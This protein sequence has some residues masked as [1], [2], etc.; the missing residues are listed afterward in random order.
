MATL[1]TTS[2]AMRLAPTKQTSSELPN[3]TGWS[4]SSTTSTMRWLFSAAEELRSKTSHQSTLSTSATALFAAEHVH[5]HASKPSTPLA[6]LSINP[7]RALTIWPML[8]R[9]VRVRALR[10]RAGWR[11]YRRGWGSRGRHVPL[12]DARGDLDIVVFARVGIPLS[13]PSCG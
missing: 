12:R 1:L 13:D 10:R 6:G 9:I 3:K 5:S 8:R 7:S 11:S 4:S 2:L